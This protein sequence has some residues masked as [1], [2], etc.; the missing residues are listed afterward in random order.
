MNNLAEEMD[1]TMSSLEQIGMHRC[2]P[3]MNPIKDTKQ[4]L[5]E[6]SAPWKKLENEKPRGETINYDNLLQA[7]REWRI[8]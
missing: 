8:R 7:W 1:Q 5:S 3:R 2:T 4:W 6:L